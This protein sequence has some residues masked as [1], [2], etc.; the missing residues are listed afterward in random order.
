MFPTIILSAWR[1]AAI[2]LL[3]LGTG[4]CSPLEAVADD[5]DTT[6]IPADDDTSVAGDDDDDSAVGWAVTEITTIKT[7]GKSV[8]W[9]HT[10]G[11]VVT[12]RP[13]YDGYYDLLV[14]DPDEPEHES[15]L[16]HDAPGAPQKHNGNPAWHPTGDYIV[17]TAE[18]EDVQGDDYDFVAIPGKGVNCNLWLTDRAGTTFQQLTFHDT[19]YEADAPAVLHPQFSPD[20][21][22]IL[23]AE[24]VAAHDGFLWGEWILK[25]ADLVIEDTGAH[26]TNE[27]SLLPGEQDAFYESHDFDSTGQRVLF[28][29]NLSAGQWEVGMDIYQL[30]LGTGGLVQLTESWS[31]WD[32]HAHYSPDGGRI[33]WMSSAELD[34]EFPESMGSQDWPDYLKTEL[35]LMDADG[36]N[37]QRLTWFNDPAHPHYRPERVIVSDTTWGP[38]GDRLLA[39]MA[40][41]DADLGGNLTTEL[42][43]IQIAPL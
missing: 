30:D 12:A 32:E 40:I 41:G 43:M 23:W 29:G 37:E 3:I 4:G 15:Y 28:S 11:L 36:S 26:L 5:D 7:Y 38:S 14:F 39:L 25:V 24:R 42:A 2:S 35:W 18:N 22:R 34:V 21:S 10:N 16:T 17:F 31:D 13:L 19:S 33:A 8:D 20:G 9:S 6:G 1:F 27:E